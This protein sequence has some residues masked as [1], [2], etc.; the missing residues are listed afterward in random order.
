MRDSSLS[1]IAYVDGIKRMLPDNRYHAGLGG[2]VAEYD[3]N[4]DKSRGIT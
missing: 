1:I 3:L 4:A 2:P